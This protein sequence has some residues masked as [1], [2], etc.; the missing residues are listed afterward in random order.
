MFIKQLQDPRPCDWSKLHMEV[1]REHLPQILDLSR[2]AEEHRGRGVLILFL[3][4]RNV[5]HSLFVQVN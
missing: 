1:V 3:C 2:K 5:I 4:F